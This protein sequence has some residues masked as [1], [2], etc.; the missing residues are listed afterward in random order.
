MSN[1]S[2]NPEPT[3]AA[4][5]DYDNAL[6]SNDE[7]AFAAE[8]PSGHLIEAI[9]R[10]W[11]LRACGAPDLSDRSWELYGKTWCAR[12]DAAYRE[13]IVRRK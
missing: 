5:D 12:Y 4:R 1:V 6:Y 9:G 10:H 3:Q 8:T 13:R 7:R 11:I 2:Y